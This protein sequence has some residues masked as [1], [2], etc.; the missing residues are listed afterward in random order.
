MDLKH[1]GTALAALLA[2]GAMTAG[3]TQTP[4]PAATVVMQP[5]PDAGSARSSSLHILSASDHDLFTRAFAAATK[6]DW[7]TAL[8]LGNQ[9][10]DAVARQLLQWRYTLDR[11]SGA[12]FSDID[13]ALK[14]AAGWPLRGS[15]YARAEAAITPDM[16]KDQLLQWFGTRT[17]A[18]PI[19]RVRLGEAL[20]ASGEKTRGGAMI[21]QGWSEGSF[22]DFTEGSIL[23]ADSAYLTPESDWAGLDNLL[24]RGEVTD[25]KRQMKRVDSKTRA[26]GEARLAL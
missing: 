19:G 5:M 12:K 15:L 22:D 6:S 2:G 21:R 3:Q 14:M 17:P 24:W 23:S 20:V 11:D 8:A 4:P 13:A 26:V 18:S 1:I 10:Q 7:V 16:N 9:G 25:A